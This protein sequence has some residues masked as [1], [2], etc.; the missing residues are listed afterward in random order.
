MNVSCQ[1]CDAKGQVGEEAE[2]RTVL[3][4]CEDCGD[5]YL[6]SSRGIRK[7]PSPPPAPPKPQPAQRESLLGT[8]LPL[9]LGRGSP[10]E[11]VSKEQPGSQSADN[12]EGRRLSDKTDEEEGGN[13]GT[14]PSRLPLSSIQAP[15]YP[16]INIP[17]SDPL[18]RRPALL[19]SALAGL[20]VGLT[21]YGVRFTREQAVSYEP[22]TA[23]AATVPQELSVDQ[24]GHGLSEDEKSLSER[25]LGDISNAITESE[26]AESAEESSAD[27]VS[28]LPSKAE[29]K[30]P[31]KSIRPA[32]PKRSPAAKAPARSKRA[33]L[34]APP[35][36]EPPE[37]PEPA[38]AEIEEKP[39]R[40]LA[41]AMAETMEASSAADSQAKSEPGALAED[42]EV[43]TPFSRTEALA[44]LASAEDRAK[45]CRS[46]AGP[47]GP[48]RLAVTFAPSGKVTTALVEGP[49]FAGTPVGSCLARAFREAKVSPFSG[50][51]V[52]VKKSVSI[53]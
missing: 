52:T 4:V 41:E 20:L 53:F 12:G 40:T 32:K 43:Y 3:W 17:V 8:E 37:E 14:R 51:P 18:W 24:G 35:P 28:D 5:R 16:V 30:Q 1:S 22:A 9:L 39:A 42:L 19:A 47:F 34:A 33:N 36:A 11:V 6:V 21:A 48:A 13:E 27:N 38:A 45:S 23:T 7:A 29:K 49:P 2:R 50:Q 15:I 44:A 10:T 25:P 26:Q 31:A 46:N